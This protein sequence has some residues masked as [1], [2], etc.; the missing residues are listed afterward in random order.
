MLDLAHHHFGSPPPSRY[1]H[2]HHGFCT[3]SPPAIDPVYL[4]QTFFIF[5]TT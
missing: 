2:P 5:P 1:V 4:L 3:F